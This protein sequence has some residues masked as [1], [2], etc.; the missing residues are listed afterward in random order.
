MPKKL[1]LDLEGLKVQSFVTSLENVQKKQVRGGD[2][3][4]PES[5]NPAA[6][7][8]GTTCIVTLCNDN[9]CAQTCPSCPTCYWKVATCWGP[10]CVD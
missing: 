9:T 5:I 10:G 1:K 2:P 3:D 7:C 4:P 8:D 6:T